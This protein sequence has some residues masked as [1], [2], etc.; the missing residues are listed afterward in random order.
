MFAVK[1]FDKKSIM[2]NNAGNRSRAGLLNE[3]NLLK[4]L[5]HPNIIKLYE[6]YEGENHIYLVQ[7]L[8]QGMLFFIN[9]NSLDNYKIFYYNDNRRGTF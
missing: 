2:L 9:Y 1:V 4:N 7:E 3:I 5:N 8:L 6:V